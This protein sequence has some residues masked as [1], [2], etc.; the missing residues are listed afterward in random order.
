MSQIEI[1]AGPY[2][3]I[4]AKKCRITICLMDNLTVIERRYGANNHLVK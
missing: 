4:D 2:E 3:L 1:M